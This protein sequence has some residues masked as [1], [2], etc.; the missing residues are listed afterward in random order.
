MQLDRREKLNGRRRARR[1]R[2]GKNER[3]S[4]DGRQNLKP[5]GGWD[6]GNYRRLSYN[7]D[8]GGCAERANMRS[9][10]GAGREIGTKMELRAKKNDSEAESQESN[11]REFAGILHVLVLLILRRRLRKN[12][13]G[14][15]L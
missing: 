12:G 1:R 13:C 15:K 14:V 5:I 4:I 9:A 6:D 8:A 2:T 7:R 3:N 11:A 10:G